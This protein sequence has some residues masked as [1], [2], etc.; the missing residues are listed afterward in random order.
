MLTTH[1]EGVVE[2]FKTSQ[3][4]RE[5][6]TLITDTMSELEVYKG[7]IE[8]LGPYTQESL[9]KLTQDMQLLANKLQTDMVDARERST[10]YASELQSMMEQNAEEVRSRLTTY[11]RKLKKRLNKDTEEIRNTVATYLGELQSRTSQNYELVREKA[12]PMISKAQEVAV[13][14]LGD[15]TSII[16]SHSDTLGAQ[17]Q[18]HGEVLKEQMEKTTEELSNAMDGKLEKVIDLLGTYAIQVREQVQSIMDKVKETA[19]ASA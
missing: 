7:N 12:E 19:A 11:T 16:K 15:L 3:F 4:S 1:A 8:G 2:N 10:Q 9:D 6:D 14:K 18:A 17:L 5:L 13:D